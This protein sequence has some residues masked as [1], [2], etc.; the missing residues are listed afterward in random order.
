M[1][2]HS[3]AQTIRDFKATDD[4]FSSD[5]LS[6][7]IIVQTEKASRLDNS[8]MIQLPRLRALVAWDVKTILPLPLFADG[9]FLPSGPYFL[10][11]GQIYEAWKLYADEL[12]SFQTT[13]IPDLE[14]AHK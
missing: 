2:E 9:S 11:H 1:T 10:F 7:T 12:S 8:E 6:S 3:I 4:V 14:D 13:V 5:F